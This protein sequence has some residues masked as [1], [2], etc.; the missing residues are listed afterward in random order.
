MRRAVILGL[1]AATRAIHLPALQRSRAF[2]IIA[3]VDPD[4]AARAWFHSEV[5]S[6]R[7]LASLSEWSASAADQT[8]R[9]AIV[10]SPPSTHRVLCL[11]ALE[12]GFH[13]FCEKPFGQGA[14][15]S[16]AIVERARSLDRMI[17]VNFEFR[18]MPILAAL[19]RP[20]VR[21][22][23]GRPLFAQVWQTA[24]EL[25]PIEGWRGERRTLR[26]FGSHPIECLLH[27]FEGPPSRITARTPN[28]TALGGDLIDI[29]T[30]EWPDGRAATITL[31]RVSRGAHRYFELRLDGEQASFRASIG[32]KAEVRLGLRASTKRPFLETRFA[33]G[34]LAWIETGVQ[35]R[36]VARNPASVFADATARHLTALASALDQGRTPPVA[37]ERA[38]LVAAVVDCAYES[39]RLGRT[40][41]F[42][43]EA[44]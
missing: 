16:R 26:E 30:L 25:D 8:E 17:A 41:D 29:V 24:C 39:A 34:G 7:T 4:P 40:L 19:D 13:L 44:P 23:L 31:D 12:K 10:A 21:Q 11:E 14:S 6:A 37:G 9:W 1:G 2:E 38:A 18:W 27:V 35:R 32:G 43:G 36:V 5:S 33:A 28:P 20:Q 3:G 15:D 22:S 42:P